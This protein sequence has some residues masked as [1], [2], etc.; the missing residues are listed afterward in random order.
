MAQ[1]ATVGGAPLAISHGLPLIA[2][3]SHQ[4]RAHVQHLLLGFG[5]ARPNKTKPVEL[6]AI[7]VARRQSAA[8]ARIGSR[9]C[10]VALAQRFPIGRPGCGC[11]SWLG[12]S[13]AIVGNQGVGRDVVRQRGAGVGQ[14]G[15]ICRASCCRIPHPHWSNE[16][17][18]QITPCTTPCVRT[19][20]AACPGC[21]G[22]ASS[23]SVVD[24]WL[25][26][27]SFFAAAACPA[28]RRP[29]YS[30][31]S[32]SASVLLRI[33]ARSGKAVA[34][35]ASWWRSRIMAAHRQ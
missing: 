25:P 24:G 29:V 22:M 17:I 13:G 30:S 23:A 27:N 33:S 12:L 3:C 5:V 20:P 15:W 10:A 14:L 1:S 11:R 32:T 6:P 19:W 18:P 35:S 7:A 2:P 26:G 21:A 28:C 16:L 4:F 9:R 31:P 34:T 8:G